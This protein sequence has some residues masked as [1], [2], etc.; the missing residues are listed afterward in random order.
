[1]RPWQ[2]RA[3]A[4]L[5]LLI[6][7]AYLPVTSILAQTPGA[8]AS[9]PT[10]PAAA[11]PVDSQ[12]PLQPSTSDAVS[13]A[14]KPVSA[15]ANS[16]Q[17]VADQEHLPFMAEERGTGSAEAPSAGGL[18]IRTAGA[19]LIIVGLIVAAGW[20]L[21]RLGGA[22]F[23]AT[24]QDSPELA[25]LSSVGLG[26]RRSLAVV[27]F[28]NRTLLIGTT[29]Q[30]ITLLADEAHHSSLSPPVARSVADLLRE[31][32]EATFDDE[33]SLA[34][35]KIEDSISFSRA[36]TPDDNPLA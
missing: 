35:L 7:S 10:R 9:Q 26:E 16:S 5:T 19:L 18:L 14:D 36:R 32:E 30:S 25:V 34:N 27:R 23:G 13:A 20:G 33:L 17:G 3:T 6:L 8:G 24:G 22:R 21:R 31:T 2:R 1:M 4:T 28:A 15:E 12:P 11:A 29:A